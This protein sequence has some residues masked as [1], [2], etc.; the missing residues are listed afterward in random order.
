MKALLFIALIWAIYKLITS[1]SQSKNDQ[2]NNDNIRRIREEQERIRLEQERSREWQR[3]ATMRQV[4]HDRAIAKAAKEREAMRKEQER[5]AAQL[6]KHEAEIAKINY[7]VAQI[8]EDLPLL[9]SKLEYQCKQMDALQDQLYK[10][11]LAVQFDETAI[12]AAGTH[13][14]VKG[15]EYDAHKA[16]VEKAES[17]IIDLQSKIRATEKKIAK[18][19]FDKAQAQRKLA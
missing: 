2:S 13:S 11:K 7:T 1:A 3:E 5:H 6:A 14:A 15:K 16:A 12:R 10:A 19:Q 8:D 17:K 9:Q 18:A 4:E